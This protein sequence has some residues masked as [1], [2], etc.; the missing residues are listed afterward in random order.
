MEATDYV[1]GRPPYDDRAVTPA[2]VVVVTALHLPRGSG[3]DVLRV[4]RSNLCDRR[5]PVIVVADD[6]EESEIDEVHRLGA[7]AFLDGSVAADVLLDVIRDTHIPWALDHNRARPVD[8]ARLA[9]VRER[10]A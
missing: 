4:V 2:P 3:L 9:P 8:P 1:H 6:A 10:G 5:T 7:A